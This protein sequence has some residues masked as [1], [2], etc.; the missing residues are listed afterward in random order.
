MATAEDILKK[1]RTKKG[2][3]QAVKRS[4]LGLFRYAVK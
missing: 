3:F 2:K 1:S 4:R